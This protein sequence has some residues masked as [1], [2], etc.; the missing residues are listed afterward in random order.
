MPVVMAWHKPGVKKAVSK[1]AV[2][3]QN[4]G[5]QNKLGNP[6]GHCLGPSPACKAAAYADVSLE[7]EGVDMDRERCHCQSS[8]KEKWRDREGERSILS[9]Q[10]KPS[11]EG[12]RLEQRH[13]PHPPHSTVVPARRMGVPGQTPGWGR[14][15]PR[16]EFLYL[17]FHIHRS[18]FEQE[19][20]GDEAPTAG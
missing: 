4:Q 11:G 2:H 3:M 1:S 9:H 10:A 19:G 17:L 16:E 14:S 7:R 20:G 18:D 8:L 5:V 15:G 12:G 6:I 13:W